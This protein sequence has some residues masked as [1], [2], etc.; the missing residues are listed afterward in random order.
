MKRIEVL[1]HIDSLMDKN[2]GE[3]KQA[4][5]IAKKAVSKE[6]RFKF[7]ANIIIFITTTIIFGSFMLMAYFMYYK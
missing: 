2:I 4:L 5:A 7:W 6:Y 3:D 1:Y